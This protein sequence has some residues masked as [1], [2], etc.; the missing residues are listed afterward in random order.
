MGRTKELLIEKVN[1][2]ETVDWE[3]EWDKDFVYLLEK[4]KEEEYKLLHGRKPRK[5][6]AKIVVVDKR[7]RKKKDEPEPTFLAL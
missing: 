7:K 3:R 1:Y 6:A 4:Q 5:K 2:V